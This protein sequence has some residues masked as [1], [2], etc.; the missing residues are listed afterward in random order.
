MQDLINSSNITKA[1]LNE[2]NQQGLQTEK[3]LNT[4]RKTITEITAELSKGKEQVTK[5]E[6]KINDMENELKELKLKMEKIQSNGNRTNDW[7]SVHC[8]YS[9]ILPLPILGILFFLT[10]KSNNFVPRCL[11]DFFVGTL[12]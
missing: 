2:E 10:K 4:A 12:I 1:R 8:L 6:N 9:L 7:K 5:L 3:T 11:M